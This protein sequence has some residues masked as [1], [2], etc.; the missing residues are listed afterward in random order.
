MW[1]G[2]EADFSRSG[3]STS[4]ARPAVAR[5]AP[6]PAS[7]PR[8][9]PSGRE[10]RPRRSMRLGGAKQ[11]VQICLEIRPYAPVPEPS[12]NVMGP[13]GIR[14]CTGLAMACSAMLIRLAD[15][16]SDGRHSVTNHSTR[17]LPNRLLNNSL[18]VRPGTAAVTMQARKRLIRL[19]RVQTS[20]ELAT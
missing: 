16:S 7:R 5:Q 12:G 10:C 8:S 15:P 17:H 14:P 20:A 18:A 4:P 11:V 13:G 9:W 3:T 19:E 6:V 2:A 1:G